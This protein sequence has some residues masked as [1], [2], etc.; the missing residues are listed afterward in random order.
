MLL[1]QK[2]QELNSTKSYKNSKR[3]ASLM[4][5]ELKLYGSWLGEKCTTK[6]ETVCCLLLPHLFGTDRWTQFL[7]LPIITIMIAYC[8]Q[9]PRSDL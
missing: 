6:S 8:Q 2:K 4:Y 9:P 3:Y 5:L 1:P 7:F